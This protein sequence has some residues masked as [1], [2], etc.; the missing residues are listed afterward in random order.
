[1]DLRGK[2]ILVTGASRGLGRSIA[3]FLAEKGAHVSG[4]SRNPEAVDWM[5]SIRL[6]GLD[7][8]SPAALKADWVE[9]GLVEEQFDIVIN[10][11]GAGSFF[12]F[13]ISDEQLWEAQISLLLR[14]PMA[15]CRL[16]LPGMLE[17]KGG[18]LVNV[19]S[20]SAEYPIPFMSGYSAAKSGLSAFTNGLASELL[21]TD[22]KVI[23]F[24]PGDFDSSFNDS[25]SRGQ[26]SEE[27]QV[28]ANR[29]WQCMVDRMKTSPS[30]E[31]IAE[32]LVAALENDRDGVVRAG[33]FF[34]RV[35][36]PLFARVAPLSAQRRANESYYKL[37]Q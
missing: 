16:V 7:L 23:D 1:M 27:K 2:K 32:C 5:D 24:R 29:V 3:E 34:Q 20:L 36:A 22:V 11:A 31:S 12:E 25:S 9:S 13:S 35:L 10:N 26:F 21:D 28:S 18:V 4:T 33:S 17:R 30:P 19:S 37:H 14:S 8:S 6:Y 15:L